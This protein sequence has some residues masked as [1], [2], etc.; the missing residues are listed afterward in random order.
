MSVATLVFAGVTV[1]SLHMLV[2]VLMSKLQAMAAPSGK[3]FDF[4]WRE[5][6]KL[7]L[8]AGTKV[9]GVVSFGDSSKLR[10]GDS[11]VAIG[12][13]LGSYP[14]TVSEG[15]VNGMHRSLGGEYPLSA[16]IQNDAKIWH[17]DSG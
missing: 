5:L 13:A 4:D 8:K 11:V 9:P 1:S 6:L 16:M 17:G 3:S 14:N 10:P 7:D 12:T 15:T 2:N